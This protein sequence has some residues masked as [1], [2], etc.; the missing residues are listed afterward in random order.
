MVKLRVSHKFLLGFTICIGLL[1]VVGKTAI[2][3]LYHI[4][5]GA[6]EIRIAK[7]VESEILECRREEKNILLFGPY[8]K[9]ALEGREE[10]NHLEKIYEHCARLKMLVGDGE[11]IAEPKERT[12]FKAMHLEIKNYE[13]ALKET[14]VNYIK[15]QDSV[16][17]ADT[18]LKDIQTAMVLRS[19]PAAHLELVADSR[20]QQNNYAIY[21]EPKYINIVRDNIEKLKGKDADNEALRMYSGYMIL[22]NQLIQKTKDLE[23]GILNMR[24]TGRSM[25]DKARMVTEFV[26]SRIEAVNEKAQ[27]TVYAALI[28]ALIFGG[29]ISIL[30]SSN[31]VGTMH[32]LT[33]ATRRVAGGD[34]AQRV[35]IKSKDELGELADSFNTMASNLQNSQEEIRSQ[36][37]ELKK[38]NEELQ[39]TNEAL[40][41]AN[42]EL[43][44]LKDDLEKEVEKRT[45]LLETTKNIM[46]KRIKEL[47]RQLGIQGKKEA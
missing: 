8:A 31:I 21:R 27:N 42:E 7:D 11:R 13:R 36:N 25:Q 32:R 20:V 18:V 47:E 16:K 23:A 45:A 35:N 10:K 44:T 9:T 37:E 15:R 29:G 1:A 33:T 39:L 43:K 24:L 14:E 19:A 6:T 3:S 26:S 40:R 22:F 46:E 41:L 30:F 12:V 4:K 28:S 5:N 2:N 38:S 34:F 17:D